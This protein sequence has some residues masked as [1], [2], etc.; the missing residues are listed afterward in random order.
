MA[1]A[2]ITSFKGI[3]ADDDSTGLGFWHLGL[4][5]IIGSGLFRA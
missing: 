1:S 5:G 2:G 4:T 3:R